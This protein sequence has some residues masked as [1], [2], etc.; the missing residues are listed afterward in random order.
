MYDVLEELSSLSVQLQNRSVTLPRA[1][2]IMRRTIRQIASM[3]EHPGDKLQEALDCTKEQNFRNIELKENPKMKRI[4]SGQFFTSINVAMEQRLLPTNDPARSSP[5][6]TVLL[7]SMKI[8]DPQN[9]PEAMTEICYLC[10]RCHFE[11]EVMQ[12]KEG[13]RDFK[14]ENTKTPEVNAIGVHSQQHSCQFC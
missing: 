12:I 3:K 10:K 8:L 11:A 1:D 2:Q 9:W 7:N 4:N 6:E 14:E 13:F 5:M